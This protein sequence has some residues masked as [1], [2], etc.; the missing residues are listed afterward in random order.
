M[1]CELCQG[2]GV[3]VHPTFTSNPDHVKEPCPLC[4]TEEYNAQYGHLS[5][6]DWFKK[7]LKGEFNNVRRT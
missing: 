7:V 2:H 5:W 6:W 1:T 3:I 4:R